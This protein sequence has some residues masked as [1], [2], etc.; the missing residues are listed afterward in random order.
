[1][2]GYGFTVPTNGYDNEDR[3]IAWNR[4]DGLK[5]QTWNLSLVGD[6]NTH[7]DA[8]VTQTRTHGPAHEFTSVT[9]G[10]N[11]SPL[12]YDVKGNMLTRPAALQSPALNLVWDFDNQLKGADIDG[13]PAIFEVTFEYD[14]LNRRVARNASTGNDVYVQ[15][16]QQTIVDYARGAAPNAPSYRYAYGSYVDEPIL[17]H[18]GTATTIPASG[19]DLLY[20]HRNQQYSMTGLSD[21]AGNLVERYSYTTHGELGIFDPGGAV[22]TTSAFANRYSYTGREWEPICKLHFFRSRWIDS[23]YG[24][25]LSRD[26]FG[27]VDGLNFYESYSRMVGTDPSGNCVRDFKPTSHIETPW[28][29]VGTILRRLETPESTGLP[30]T[31]WGRTNALVYEIHCACQCKNYCKRTVK[32][33]CK[34]VARIRIRINTASF[35]E[36]PTFDDNGTRVTTDNVYGHEQLHVKNLLEAAEKAAA[37]VDS[38]ESFF[39]RRD[40]D[41]ANCIYYKSMMEDYVQR[42]IL[43]PAKGAEDIHQ[44]THPKKSIVYDPEGRRPLKPDNNFPPLEYDKWPDIKCIGPAL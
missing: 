36:F 23:T 19:T 9:I 5:N 26:S 3:V 30:V 29:E 42:L 25:F 4:T 44:N 37:F 8:G 21:A 6:W 1:M 16:G 39:N 13:T 7:T 14:A 12:T 10:G 28:M 2:S 32:I 15:A 24:R 35:V 27:F 40:Y 22:R 11:N 43:N 18:S 34:I 41:F 17:R 31:T 38:R 33:R 20:Y